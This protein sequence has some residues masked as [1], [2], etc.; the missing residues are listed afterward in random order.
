MH[1][2]STCRIGVPSA[3]SLTQTRKLRL[4]NCWTVD[5][6]Y[7]RCFSADGELF[8]GKGVPVD[9]TVEKMED[10]IYRA[11]AQLPGDA[12]KAFDPCIRTAIDHILNV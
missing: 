12:A 7:M 6:P 2:P 5:I 4:P 9:K 8:E 1:R 10:A 11:R 3:G